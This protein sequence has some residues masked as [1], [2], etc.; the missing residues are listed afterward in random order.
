MANPKCKE[1]DS[2]ANSRRL[3]IE[4]EKGGSY[5]EEINKCGRSR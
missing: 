2:D 5:G 1:R 4:I 3:T